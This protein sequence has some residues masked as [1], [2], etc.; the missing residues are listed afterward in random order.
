MSTASKAAGRQR[1]AAVVAVLLVVGV[2]VTTV[3]RVAN[4]P[5]RVVR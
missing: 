1:L 3:G 5:L 2:V 4:E